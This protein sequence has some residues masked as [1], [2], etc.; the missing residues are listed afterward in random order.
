MNT[1][2][3]DS[4][5]AEYPARFMSKSWEELKGLIGQEAGTDEVVGADSV[6]YTT[7]R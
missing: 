7:L 1:T 5:A 6:A 2:V 3:A 4:I